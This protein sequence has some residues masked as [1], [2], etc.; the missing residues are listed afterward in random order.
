MESPDRPIPAYLRPLRKALRLQRFWRLKLRLRNKLTV[1]E[2]VYFGKG[3]DL[4][5]PAFATF[6]DH[7]SVGKNLT[8]EAN[9]TVGSGVL[10][11][12]NVSIVGDDHK[13][14]QS[15]TSVFFLGRNPPSHV[16]L[17]GDNLIGFGTIIVGNVTV[18]HGCIVG[19][20]SVVVKDLP[21][22]T[23]C[24]GVPARVIRARR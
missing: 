20:G 12:S 14:D 11:S 2:D 6:S 9:L 22:N 3:A 4:R 19:A 17:E 18:G 23:V 1:G 10:I 15:E 24:A 16:V 13:F 7:V 21:P 5:P 8:L